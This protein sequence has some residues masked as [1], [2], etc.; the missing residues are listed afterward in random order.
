[1]TEGGKDLGNVSLTLVSDQSAGSYQVI[2]TFRRSRCSDMHKA[3]VTGPRYVVPLV[4][5]GSDHHLRSSAAHVLACLH[6]CLL[7]Y[8]H[9]C[10][11]TE[12]DGPVS[13]YLRPWT[14][15]G[16]GPTPSLSSN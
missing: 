15:A 2:H 1:V 5:E 8:L 9:A 13:T 14:A 11:L 16:A 4:A 10:M 6:A 7:T 12:T 3:Y